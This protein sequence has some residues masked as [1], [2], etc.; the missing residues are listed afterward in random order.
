MLLILVSI[1]RWRLNC[2]CD[3][4]WRIVST[5]RDSFLALTGFT[6]GRR[7]FICKSGALL[8][9]ETG[10]NESSS[11]ISDSG[12]TLAESSSRKGS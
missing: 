12:L 10:L 11:D 7:F 6:G 1:V 3:L 9:G 5:G 8:D 2:P 4:A